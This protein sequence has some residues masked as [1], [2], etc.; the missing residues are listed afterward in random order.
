M[1]V[2]DESLIQFWSSLNN[3]KVA[4]IMEGGF[5]VNMHGFS[6]NT[7]GIDVWLKDTKTNRINFGK[8]INVLGYDGISWQDLQFV[9]GWTNFTIGAGIILGIMTTMK[10]LN[11]IDFDKAFKLASIAS[12]ENLEVPF[13]HI[14][15][16]I[17][18]KKAV[19]RPKDQIDV[20]ELEKI[21]KIREEITK[22]KNQ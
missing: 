11:N 6:R 15:Q 7:N 8:A 18:N 4:Y 20:I 2:L 10:G 3:Y 12:I 13:L 21:L 14:N 9:P 19:N 1:D 5:A 16:L 17:D 22:G